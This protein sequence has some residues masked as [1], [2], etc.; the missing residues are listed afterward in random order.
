MKPLAVLVA[1]SLALLAFAPFAL[2][3]G[4]A[5]GGAYLKAKSCAGDLK[6]QKE[7]ASEH[8]AWDECVALFEG[9]ASAFPNSDQAAK[10]LYSAG[11][12]RLEASARF[13]KTSDVAEALRLFNELIRA[14]PK[15]T[16]ADDALFQVGRLRHDSLR[17]DDRARRAFSYLIENYPQG[18]MVEKARAELALLGPGEVGDEAPAEEESEPAKGATEEKDGEEKISKPSPPTGEASPRRHAELS[19]IQVERGDEQTVVSLTLSR[20]AAYSLE[21]I[22]EGLRTRA[23][24][25]LEMLLPYTRPSGELS[26]DIAVTSPELSNIKVRQSLLGGGVKLSFRLAPTA[27]YA[28]TTKGDRI[29]IRFAREGAKPSPPAPPPKPLR[30]RKAKAAAAKEAFVIVIDPGHGGSDT[31]AIGPGGTLEKDVTLVLARRLAASLREELKVRVLFTRDDDRALSLEERSAFA[32]S[33]GADLFLSVHA[34]A[35]RDRKMAGIETYFLNTAT[36]QAAAK[37]AERE[38]RSARGKL[39]DVQHIL[40]T[41]LQT[42][43]AADSQMLAG[44]VQRSLIGRMGKRYPGIRNRRV[45]SALFYVLV[46]AKCPA[47]LVESSFLS[48][49]REEKRLRNRTY[50]SDLAIAIA[51]GVRRYVGSEGRRLVSL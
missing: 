21:Y 49:P 32:A 39:S 41:M 6:V 17:D 12:L 36:D 14:H 23:P 35:S 28:V 11:R 9:V 2:A 1:A 5:E 18:D 40:S 34:N 25:R 26:R 44:D 7:R 27:S 15:S 31:G 4:D 47:I 46:G 20:E 10:A 43:T 29:T 16:L 30:E 42:S 45:R 24:P 37:L 50:Q 33:K 19:A 3:A 38:N 51:D 22:E 48:N 13:R 8:D